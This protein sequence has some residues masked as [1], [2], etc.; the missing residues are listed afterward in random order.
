LASGGCRRRNAADIVTRRGLG[1]APTEIGQRSIYGGNSIRIHQVGDTAA[2]RMAAAVYPL[3]A[4]AIH[5]RRT[6][7]G[8]IQR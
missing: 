3:A 1:A 6:F 2:G 8:S 7:A 4:S 5:A